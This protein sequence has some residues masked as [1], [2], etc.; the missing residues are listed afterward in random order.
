MD[1]AARAEEL[2][3]LCEPEMMDE[4]IEHDEE[5][6]Q[7]IRSLGG[8]GR[9]YRRHQRAQL[10]ALVSE[11]YS[12]PR[13]TACAELMSWF[14]IVPGL[15]LDLTTHDAQGVAW[16]F[17]VAERREAARKFLKEQQP[18]FLIGSPMCTA[19]SSWQRLD[20]LKRDGKVVER[21]YTKAMLH[22]RFVCELYAMQVSE[23]RYFLH[24][25]PVAAS[26][27][28]D[29]CIQ[30]VLELPGVAK[31]TGDQCQYGQRSAGG[32]PVRK[33]TGWMSNC[34]FVLGA[35]SKR[36]KGRGGRC[37]A[38]SSRSH[39]ICEGRVARDAAVYPMRLC[40]AI[41]KGFQ[42]QL[43]HDGILKEG[44]QGMQVEGHQ[45]DV[46]TMLTEIEEIHNVRVEEEALTVQ[47]ARVYKDAI[48]G[49]TLIP[50]LV[51]AARREELRY[52][53]CKGVWVKRPRAEALAR[54]G[55]PP[56]TVKWVDVNTGDDEA[57]RYR[58]RL[59]AREIRLPGQDSIF[60]P[61]PPLESLRTVLSLAA[62]EIDGV[63][64]HERCPKSEQRTQISVIDISRAYFNAAKDPDG[65]P[66]YVDL[67]SE[68][69]DKAKGLCGLLQV[70]MYGTRAAADGWHGEYSNF[71]RS[72]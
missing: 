27:W 28:Q 20:D 24:E 55:R 54:T 58:S 43:R 5:T 33:P 31:K 72:R 66:T 70:H 13:V 47:G 50:E 22:L 15:A 41:L 52:L 21:E 18:L 46:E 3:G 61:T 4:M 1:G 23:G 62:T 10:R 68:D 57:P 51:E 14:G 2:M 49:Q 30:E 39:V 37:S 48:T 7:V 32:G 63:I 53:L 35:P 40:R 11:V 59:V 25:H 36:C 42:Q 71:L 64:S 9:R 26:S 6:M 65:D 44:I 38:D 17:D 45:Q 60:A 19:F 34:P 56:I 16:D 69:A 29:A 8:D 67:P 12:P